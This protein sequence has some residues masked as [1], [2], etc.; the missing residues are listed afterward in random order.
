M[1][2]DIGGGTTD[3]AIFQNGS[4]V[5]TAVIALGGS[6][7]YLGRYQQQL[8]E[9]ELESL[10]FEARIVANVPAAQARPDFKPPQ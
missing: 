2:V 7:V 8:I 5:H 6:L 1:I 10:A 4:I 9:A 3:I